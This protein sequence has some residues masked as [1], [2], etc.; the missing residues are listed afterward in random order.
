LDGT[1]CLADAHDIIK[2]LEE[3]GEAHKQ[4]TFADAIVLNKTDLVDD[5]QLKH[6]PNQA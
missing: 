6:M 3:R 4:V 2:N 5:G 1:I